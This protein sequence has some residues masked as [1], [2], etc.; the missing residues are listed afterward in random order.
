M[1]SAIWSQKEKGVAWP[2]GRHVHFPQKDIEKKV[3]STEL[4]QVAKN[5]FFNFI[6]DILILWGK[7]MPIFLN[8]NNVHFL[9]SLIAKP[10]LSAHIFHE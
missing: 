1:I 8:F 2:G 5:F 9:P 3:N 10:N 7:C 4:S 6:F